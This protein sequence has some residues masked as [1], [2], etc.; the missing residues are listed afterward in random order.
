MFT[1]SMLLLISLYWL[2]HR[3][4]NG[5]LVA[6]ALAVNWGFNQAAMMI[7]LGAGWGG[8]PLLVFWAVDM[9]T[10]TWLAL[11]VGTKLARRAASWFVPMLALNAAIWASGS[12]PQWHYHILL[13]L[14][15]G[16]ALTVLI[17]LWGHGLLEA[18]DNSR[19]RLRDKLVD[20]LAFIGGQ[21]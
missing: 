10:A 7:W 15:Y 14:A 19:H 4:E 18:I 21:R 8:S 17:G 11:Y 1:P 20:A 16:Q 3:H 5:K 2:A 9:L 6:D 12:D 13:G